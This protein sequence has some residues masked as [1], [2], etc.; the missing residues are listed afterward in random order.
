[1][2]TAVRI[3]NQTEKASAKRQTRTKKEQ[4]S[5]QDLKKHL[6][7][8]IPK[9]SLA[10]IREPGLKVKVNS[11]SCPRDILLFL[12][13]LKTYPEEHFVSLHLNAKNQVVGYQEVSHGTIS[14]SLVSPREV[15]KA[16]ILS[17][18]FAL[19]VAHNHPS[20]AQLSPSKEDLETTKQLLKAGKILGI[21]VLDHVI[22]GGDEIYSIREN[23][24][25]IWD[26][27]YSQL[28]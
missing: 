26:D 2:N 10:L 20:G 27:P 4:T 17:N 28:S 23:H 14:A 8:L 24:P 7:Y 15:F 18:S 21:T 3:E 6:Q 25:R 5:N 22:V 1:M 12:E 11:I 16:A 19:L 13:P 9:V